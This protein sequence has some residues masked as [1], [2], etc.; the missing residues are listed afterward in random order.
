MFGWGTFRTRTSFD[1]IAGRGIDLWFIFGRPVEGVTDAHVERVLGEVADAARE[2]DV[3]VVLYPHS[4]CYIESAEEALPFVRRLDRSNLGLAVHL[5][6]ELRAGNGA[7]IEEVVRTTSPYLKAVTLAGADSVVDRSSPRA[8]NKST[9]K[10]LDQ[11]SY[12]LRRMIRALDLVGYDGPVALMNFKI[13][14]EPSDYLA[15]SIEVWRR[16]HAQP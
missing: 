2:R 15:R 5:Y 8:V 16:I 13:E 6:H 7:R 11:G 9:I 3:D 14:A 12:D 10:P 1:K 4:T